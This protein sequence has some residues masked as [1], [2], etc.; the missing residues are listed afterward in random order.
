M[1]KKT[2]VLLSAVVLVAA[3]AIPYWVCQ[4]G[5][6]DLNENVW[7]ELPGKT[8]KLPEGVTYYQWHGPANG[9]VAVLIHGA[10]MS[11]Y[12]WGK[13]VDALAKAGFRV[14][15]YDNLGRGYSERPAIKYDAELYD[16]QL[17]GLLAS[18]GVKGRVNLVGLSQ[19][20][21][22]AV[23]FAARHPLMVKKVA[24]LAPAGFPLNVPSVARLVRKP[25]IGEWIMTVLG[26][27]I[28]LSALPE[29]F[30]DQSNVPE[31]R[32]K[33]AEQLDY[34]G[35]LPALLSMLRH[36]PLETLEKEYRRFGREEIPTLL[37]WG[38]RDKTIPLENADKVKAAIPHAELTVIPGGGHSV[39][40]EQP[41]V[42]NPALVKFLSR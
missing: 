31:L 1:K 38:D 22:I 34:K 6:K 25:L 30:Q 33:L 2:L 42:V 9:P 39:L 23:V 24:L 7:A 16:R 12:I 20:G 36:Y 13:N 40:Y 5:F 28:L 37:I 27:R 26:R 8:V 4:M 19:G 35:F 15:T 14:L 10:T 11:S 17:G 18:L 41:G 32:S 3:V 21:A 29:G